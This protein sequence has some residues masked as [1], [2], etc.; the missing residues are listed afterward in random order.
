MLD[1]GALEV[2][3]DEPRFLQPL[4]PGGE[5]IGSWK[6]VT[7]LSPLNVFIQQAV[8]D[9]DSH[10]SPNIYQKEQL[11]GGHR[12]KGCVFPSAH[13][14]D[15]SKVPTLCLPRHDLSCWPLLEWLSDLLSLLVDF[16]REIPP[17]E[18]LPCQPRSR[19][20]SLNVL[21]LN[22]HAWRL[23]SMSFEREAFS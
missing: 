3:E 22:L 17:C 19:G 18:T 21:A 12:P 6:P 5:G 11:L 13:V 16:P 14:L 2:V 9:G 4:F 20:Y 7:D 10:F 1:K 23:S 8:Q 15:I